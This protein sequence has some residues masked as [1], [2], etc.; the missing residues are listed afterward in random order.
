MIQRLL[1]AHQ[2]LVR[3]FCFPE[4]RRIPTH[5]TLAE[6]YRLYKLAQSLNHSDPV[7]VEI[8]SYL[9]ASSVCVAS[10][11][12]GRGTLYCSDTWENDAMSA[13]SRHTYDEFRHNTARFQKNIVEVKGWSWDVVP[14]IRNLNKCV[15]I[16][17]IDGDHSYDGVK[18]DWDL[19]SPFLVSGSIIIMHDIGWAEGVK[20]VAREWVEPK[21]VSSQRLPNLFWG[22]IR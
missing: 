3:H 13:G 9:G 10:G 4:V 17:F 20:Q 12:K 22:I 19:Y 21:L 18:K 15:D 2:A 1:D 14:T 8:G 16:L 5:L 11:L 7:V 6:Q